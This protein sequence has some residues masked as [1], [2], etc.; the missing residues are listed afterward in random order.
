M[1]AEI[2]P[3]VPWTRAIS[4]EPVWVAHKSGNFGSDDFFARAMVAL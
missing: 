1:G 3:S 4:G 2:E